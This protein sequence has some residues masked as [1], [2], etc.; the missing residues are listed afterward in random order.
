MGKAQFMKKSFI[1]FGILYLL[2]AVGCSSADSKVNKTLGLDLK[3]VATSNDRSNSSDGTGLAGGG[4]VAP[5]KE[6]E[7]QQVGKSEEV[8]QNELVKSNVSQPLGKKGRGEENVEESGKEVKKDKEEGKEGKSAGVLDSS[9]GRAKEEGSEESSRSFQEKEKLRVEECDSSNMCVDEKSNMVA[10]LRVPGNES[11]DLSL[12]IQN[13]GERTLNIVIAA[14]EFVRLEKTEVQLQ[15]K[16]DKKVK[17]SIGHDGI[18]SLIILTTDDGRCSLDFKDFISQNS[19]A[20]THKAYIYLNN[21]TRTH[22]AIFISV[23]AFLILASASICIGFR[24]KYFQSNGYQ[25]VSME[26]PVSSDA[27]I[28]SE[29]NEGWE[30]N[31]DDNWED[32]EAPKTSN[33]PIT[34]SLSLRGLASRRLSKEGWKD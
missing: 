11:P 4:I 1:L 5:V 14:P 6:E 2:L 3:A 10:C 26:L 28:E 21:L 13:K 32:E 7:K 20:E 18:D 34:P 27:K 9:Q 29:T 19:R 8:I 31:W 12:L 23:T 33:M 17:V 22:Y 24:R 16:E 30:N 25:T 15:A